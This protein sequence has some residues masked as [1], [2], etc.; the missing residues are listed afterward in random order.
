MGMPMGKII[1]VLLTN[2]D[3]IPLD[4]TLRLGLLRSTRRKRDDFLRGLRH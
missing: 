1:H 4:V 2:G 3:I